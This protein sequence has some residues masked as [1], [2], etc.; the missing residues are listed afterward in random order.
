MAIND[1]H[2]GEIPIGPVVINPGIVVIGQHAVVLGI[3][4]L[5]HHLLEAL[6]ILHG[7]VRIGA[8][9]LRRIGELV[10]KDTGGQETIR[11]PTQVLELA[12][13]GIHDFHR[14]VGV[15]GIAADFPAHGVGIGRG[16]VTSGNFRLVTP[17]INT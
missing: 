3:E 2:T 5:E 6:E 4:Y 15:E 9:D 10:A 11:T 1:G 16:C 13:P 14:L 17:W 12:R 8:H 7:P